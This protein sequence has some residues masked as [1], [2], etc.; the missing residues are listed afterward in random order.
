MKDLLIRG[1]LG[2][3][4]HILCNGLVRHFAKFEPDRI[5]HVPCKA[6][7]YV[8]VQWMFSD[9]DN[10]NVRAFAGDLEVDRAAQ[11]LEDDGISEVM[12]LGGSGNGFDEQ[13]Y[14]QAGV[15]FEERWSGFAVPPCETQHRVPPY[16]FTFIHD[17]RQRGFAIPDPPGDLP[18]VRSAYDPKRPNIFEW[19]DML[20]RAAEIHCI[21]SSFSVLV[22]EL[23]GVNLAVGQKLFLH[24][25]ARPNCELPT[26]RKNWTI[27]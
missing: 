9:L 15:P 26:Y 10:V 20:L 1:H 6:H 12:R 24:A 5:I 18:I 19:T 16:A 11:E 8:S 27:V 13:F 2:L 17:D 14:Q 4:D 7:N 21:P 23:W 25:S 3:G 22:D